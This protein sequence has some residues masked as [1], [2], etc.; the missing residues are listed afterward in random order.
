MRHILPYLLALFT[1]A[2]FIT[3]HK[4]VVFAERL[5]TFFQ[6]DIHPRLRDFFNHGGR[7][8]NIHDRIIHRYILCIRNELLRNGLPYVFVK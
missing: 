7:T 2:L 3:E 6:I 8:L 5:R 4:A 1:V